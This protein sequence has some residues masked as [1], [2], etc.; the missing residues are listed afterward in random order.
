MITKV[1]DCWYDL[2]EMVN[3]KNV[4]LYGSSYGI[5]S[6]RDITPCN[7]IDTPLRG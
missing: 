6:G 4:R 5:A 2:G 1:L 7:K 3:V